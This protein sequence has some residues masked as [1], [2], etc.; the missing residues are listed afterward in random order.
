MSVV[1]GEISYTNIR[2]F[3]FYLDRPM[4]KEHNCQFVPQVPAQLNNEMAKG[5]VDIGGI[6]SFAYAEH[7]LEYTLLPNLSVTSYGAVNSIFLFSKVP[8]NELNGKKVALTWSS[9]SSVN[10]LK[11]ILE[12]FY[13]MTISYTTMNPNV[14]SMLEDHDACLLIG[15]DAIV[16]KR[17]YGSS[18]HH[19]DL[20][21]LWFNQ[22]GL[23]MTFAVFAVRNE[24]LR[25]HPSLVGLIYRSFLQSKLESESKNYQPM[26]AEIVK[27]HGGEK[28]F[29]DHYFQ[30]LCNDFGPE[31]QKGLFYY[32][33]LLYKMK[34]LTN[35]VEKL[36][37]WDGAIS[38]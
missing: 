15:D 7:A 22:T 24:T 38:K 19:Y 9:A 18:L 29:W 28:S 13:S 34:Y 23:P 11:I 32:Y 6:S 35:P 16:A 8:I 33:Q 26:I 1:I 10:L 5:R 14:G 30:K 37:I 12:H 4:L 25:H 21:E 27:S 20:G 31:E 2:P 3:F 17:E 36:Q